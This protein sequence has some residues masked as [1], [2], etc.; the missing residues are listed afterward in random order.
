MVLQFQI[1][2][3]YVGIKFITI[4]FNIASFRYEHYIRRKYYFS[5]LRR[6][7]CKMIVIMGK[8]FAYDPLSTKKTATSVSVILNQQ[9]FYYHNK[10]IYLIH[11]HGGDYFMVLQFQIKILALRRIYDTKSI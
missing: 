7:N 3:Q 2:V 1:S 5:I 11:I 6:F 10:L 8:Y 4:F 9:H